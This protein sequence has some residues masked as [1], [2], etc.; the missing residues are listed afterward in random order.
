MNLTTR[1]VEGKGRPIITS[2]NEKTKYSS[3]EDENSTHK[4]YLGT[5]LWASPV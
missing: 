5:Y 4:S 3:G 2:L 1:I